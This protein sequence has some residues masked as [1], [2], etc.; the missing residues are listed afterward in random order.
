MRARLGLAHSLWAA[1]AASWP[2]AEVRG[3]RALD[4]ILGKT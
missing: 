2:T 4:A 3:C 1:N